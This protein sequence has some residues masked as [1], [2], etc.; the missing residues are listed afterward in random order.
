[1]HQL[2]IC[3]RS[4]MACHLM[5]IKPLSACS[6]SKYWCTIDWTHRKTFHWNFDQFINIFIKEIVFKNAVS[7]MSAILSWPQWV[8]FTLE[9]CI[10][11]WKKPG[12]SPEFCP[13]Q[14]VGT[15]NSIMTS[16]ILNTYC[17]ITRCMKG[18]WIFITKLE[19]PPRAIH[20]HN[21]HPLETIGHVWW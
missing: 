15:L 2:A 14:T 1:M 4:L 10:F 6:L 13:F 3:L 18:L 11:T 5:N 20:K 8:K 19:W 7:W 16:H 12:K 17:D 9:N 21:P